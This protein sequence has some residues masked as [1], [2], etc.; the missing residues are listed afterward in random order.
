MNSASL[1]DYS[2]RSD[3]AAT[4]PSVIRAKAC[5]IPKHDLSHRVALGLIGFSGGTLGGMLGIGGGSAIAPLLLLIGTLRPATVS[6]TT[7]ATVVLISGV[8]SAAY[9]S[10]GYL[11]LA[12]AWPI[13]MGSV[14]GA[15]LGALAAGRLSPRLMIGLFLVILP[16]FAAKELWPTFAAPSISAGLVSLVL[17]GG[18]T[19][20]VSG[21]L[22]I[23]GASLV[24][25]SLVGFFLIDHHAAQGIAISVAL[26]DSI[27]GTAT[28]SRAGNVDYRA[29]LYLAPPA[30]VAA[31][32]G[33]LISGLLPDVALRYLFVVFMGAAWLSLLFRLAK[34]QLAPPC[35]VPDRNDTALS[36]SVGRNR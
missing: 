3:S 19:G 8:G 7:L 12:L 6:G 21:L 11:N 28:H 10:L 29:L 5:G 4:P 14:V 30:M 2:A 18:A 15:V 22:G 25:P 17:L 20:F 33:A 36:E 34:D 32:G 35:R 26:A 13:A 24:V 27:A 23:S 31:L 9:A 1:R 16:Y